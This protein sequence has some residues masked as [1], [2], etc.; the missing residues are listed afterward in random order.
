MEYLLVLFEDVDLVATDDDR[1]RLAQ[2]TG[3]YAMGLVGEGRLAGGARLRP[4]GEAQ[5]V[6]VRDGQTRVLDGPF[7]ESKEIIAGWMVVEADSMDDAVKLAAACP[8]VA[9]G[10]V[11]VHE[12]VPRS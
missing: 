3:E 10:S 12:V 6:R 11:Q 1:A 9:V 8:N 4:A 5:R 7:V 2:R